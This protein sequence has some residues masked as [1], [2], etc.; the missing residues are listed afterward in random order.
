MCQLQVCDMGVC[1]AMN[2]ALLRVLTGEAQMPQ[3][4]GPNQYK[5]EIIKRHLVQVGK[6]DFVRY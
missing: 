1:G 4:A 5:R 6:E 3:L 2:S